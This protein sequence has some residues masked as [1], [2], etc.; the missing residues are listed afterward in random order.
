MQSE[1]VGAQG[2]SATEAARIERIKKRLSESTRDPKSR[3]EVC[4]KDGRRITGQ[5]GEI[6]DDRFIL[7]GVPSGR[8]MMI[9][10]QDVAKITN[11][12]HSA[13][14]KFGLAA[15]VGGTALLTVVA[16]VAGANGR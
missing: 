1:V 11:K 8:P 5:L 4:L 6:R 7:N 16:I 9:A 14:T 2:N 12:S 10:Y 15:L 3:L 13:F